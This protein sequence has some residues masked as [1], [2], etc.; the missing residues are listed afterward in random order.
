MS[1]RPIPH[2]CD[3]DDKPTDYVA[4]DRDGTITPTCDDHV[5][6]FGEAYG[7]VRKV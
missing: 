2:R 3:W 7:A 1:H 5:G 6:E 4:E